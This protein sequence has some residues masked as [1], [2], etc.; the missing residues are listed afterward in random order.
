LTRT[1]PGR[2]ARRWLS[3]A[4]AFANSYLYG[5]NSGHLMDGFLLIVAMFAVFLLLAA[6]GFNYLFLLVGMA[7][8]FLLFGWLGFIDLDRYTL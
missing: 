8:A 1:W 2:R 4:F 5:F 6:L 3:F 7:V